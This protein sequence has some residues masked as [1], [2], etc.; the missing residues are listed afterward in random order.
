MPQNRREEKRGVIPLYIKA[1]LVP[2]KCNVVELC[3]AC[4]RVTGH[5]SIDG[6]TLLNRLWRVLPF[7]EVSRA[8]LLVDGVR[9]QGKLLKFEGKNPFLH[10]SGQGEC[11]S[12][13]L[14]IKNLP[15]SYSQEPLKET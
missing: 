8:K 13:R 9:F 15:F 10:P 3:E 2:D 14:I 11:Q 4:E 6:A 7:N 1:E 12:T 5:G